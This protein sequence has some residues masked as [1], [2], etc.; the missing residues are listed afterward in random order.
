MGRSIGRHPYFAPGFCFGREEWSLDQRRSAEIGELRTSDHTRQQQLIQTLTVMQSLQ[1]QV[2]TLQ[3]QVTTLQGHVTA[4]Q[5]QHGPLG[6]P[7]QLELPE[8]AGSSS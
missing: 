7:A 2:T 4:L 1:G 3:R 8:E 5:G 6:G